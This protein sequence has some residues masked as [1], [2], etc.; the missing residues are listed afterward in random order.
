[1]HTFSTGTVV[2]GSQSWG[3]HCGAGEDPA[4]GRREKGCCGPPH[5]G[6]VLGAEWVQQCRRDENLFTLN[7]T[8]SGGKQNYF[9]RVNEGLFPISNLIC[10]W[11]KKRKELSKKKIPEEKEKSKYIFLFFGTQALFFHLLGWESD[12]TLNEKQ[13]NGKL[14]W[15]WRN[16][17]KMFL[18]KNKKN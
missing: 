14:S 6:F 2:N 10:S 1:M 16:D 9:F 13:R 17:K 8:A 3:A 5:N 12:K 18:E 15:R 4:R 7:V 11:V